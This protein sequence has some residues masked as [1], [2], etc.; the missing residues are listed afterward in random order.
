MKIHMKNTL[1]FSTSSSN[2]IA[3]QN[4]HSN[5]TSPNSPQRL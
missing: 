2:C 5:C 4:K 1:L 3:I